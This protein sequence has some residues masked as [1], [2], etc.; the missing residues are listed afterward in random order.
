MLKSLRR[1]ANRVITPHFARPSRRSYNKV[2]CVGWLRTGTTSFAAAMRHLGFLHFTY[3]EDVWRWFKAGM[4]DRVI[5]HAR[6]WE[7]F[8]DLPWSKT[9]L[10]PRLDEEFPG[11]RFVLL[12][13]EPDA[14]LDSTIRF[15]TQRA[16]PLPSEQELREQLESRNRK[17]RAFFDG[18]PDDLLEMRICDG[19][20][21]ERLCPFLE[22]PIPADPFPHT[23]RGCPDRADPPSPVAQERDTDRGRAPRDSQ[24]LAGQALA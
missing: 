13:R 5:R 2:F 21:Y 7:S 19:Q 1:R 6:Q 23:N 17:V 14:W 24:T 11:S 3:D 10:L 18:R 4:V 20:G 16:R 12:D 8:D 15:G 9:G 22:V